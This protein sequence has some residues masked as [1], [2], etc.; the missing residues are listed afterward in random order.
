[1]AYFELVSVD[2]VIVLAT[3]QAYLQFSL[4]V[5]PGR[6]SAAR[7]AK[8]KIKRHNF[9][10]KLLWFLII[11]YLFPQVLGLGLVPES[12]YLAGAFAEFLGDVHQ[13]SL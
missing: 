8:V 12:H 11:V 10:I 7:T 4:L 1:M 6:I 2:L 9:Q 13:T 5:F 3:H